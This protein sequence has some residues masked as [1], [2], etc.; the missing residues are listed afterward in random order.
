MSRN[1]R[2]TVRY[3]GGRYLGW[4]H[5]PGS[6][7][8]RT[9]QGK[10]E[11]VLTRMLQEEKAEGSSVRSAKSAKGGSGTVMQPVDV[12]GA[13]RTDAGVHAQAMTASVVLDTSKSAS[14]IGDYLNRYLPEDISVD[15]CTEAPLRF[16]ARY[17]ATGKTYCYTCWTGARKPV[18]DRRY[19]KVLEG[20]PDVDKMREAAGCLIG[21]HDFAAFCTLPGKN[22]ST[23]RLLDRIEIAE[24]GPYLRLTF[25]GSGFLRNMVRILTGTLLEVGFGRMQPSEIPAILASKDRKQAGPTA[26]P[27][28]LTLICVDY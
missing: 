19:L 18:F 21:E 1:Y 16:H 13:G 24:D 27:Q 23:V 26:E 6:G 25:H 11:L 15:E 10:L 9:I 14:E 17:N 7:M 20:R 8:E 5:Q 2:L 22:K 12:I 4:Q 3:D 28:G